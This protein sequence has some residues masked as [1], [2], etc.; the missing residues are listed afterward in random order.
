MSV[1]VA[2]GQDVWRAGV[3]GKDERIVGGAIQ[4]HRGHV[5]HV[6]QRFA[7]G[8]VDL[9]NTTQAVGV[10]YAAAIDVRLPDLTVAKKSREPCGDFD[11]T[12][13]RSCLM[14]TR[15]I[16]NGRSLQRFKRH[17]AGEIRQIE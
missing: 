4:F 6:F 11:L 10:L 15:V 2:A 1:K 7:D 13:V 17:G 16:G 12:A 9:R 14:N 8:S 5:P 3:A